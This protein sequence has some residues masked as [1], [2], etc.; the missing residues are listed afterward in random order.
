MGRGT[1]LPFMA[2]CARY[3]MYIEAYTKVTDEST[4]SFPHT[5]GRVLPSTDEGSR[6][7]GI[8]T[9]TGYRIPVCTTSLNFISYRLTGSPPL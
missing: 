8:T 3:L 5:R 6:Q 9:L 1:G 2:K 7:D 4:E